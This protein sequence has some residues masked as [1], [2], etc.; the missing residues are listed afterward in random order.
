MADYFF[1]KTT[2]NITE[3]MVLSIISEAGYK[4]SDYTYSPMM[5]S[6]GIKATGSVV[7]NVNNL[8]NAAK[9]L[10]IPVSI[11]ATN[12]ALATFERQELLAEDELSTSATNYGVTITMSSTTVSAL[13]SGNYF[14]YGFK[15]VQA[16]QG[17]G[18]PLVWF[19]TDTYSTSTAVSWQEQYQ[20]YTSNSAIIPN[21]EVVASFSADIDLGQTLQVQAGGIGDVVSGGPATAISI[22]NQTTKQYT[23]GVSQMQNGTSSPIC[24]FPLYGTQMDVIAPIERVLLMF[25]TL[26]VNTG[27][28]IEQA[29]SSGILIDLTSSNQRS[30]TFDIN[31]GWSWG[32]YSWAQQ[33]P[34]NSDLVPLLIES[35][36]VSLSQKVLASL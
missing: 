23:C 7:M 5:T 3:Q 29:Y 13:V 32:G 8:E 34:P 27:T 15:A 30:V 33:V 16:T 14:L 25:S 4:P 1:E 17:G 22:L 2:R 19:Q 31:L 28:V 18:A 35:D 12:D 21:G 24:A 6:Q 10:K 20:A 26:P 9:R 36:S 11:S